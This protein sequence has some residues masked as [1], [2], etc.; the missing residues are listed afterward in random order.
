MQGGQGGQ[1][2]R[3]GDYFET[4]RTILGP[5]MIQ[6]ARG[7]QRKKEGGIEAD[8]DGDEGI[9]SN[10]TLQWIDRRGSGL[11]QL[12]S[13]P[14]ILKFI[15]THVCSALWPVSLLIRLSYY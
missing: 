1:L 3:V 13:V 12:I 15:L 14:L 8:E 9:Q 10:A 11:S 5:L 2:A 4:P 7:R 6:G